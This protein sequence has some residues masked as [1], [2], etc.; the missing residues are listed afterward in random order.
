[1]T[2]T[3]DMPLLSGTDQANP[4]RDNEEI[5]PLTGAGFTAYLYLLSVANPREPWTET[6][7]TRVGRAIGANT[8]D[9]EAALQE[10]ADLGLIKAAHQP[11]KPSSYLVVGHAT[12]H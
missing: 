1:M 9:A 12:E 5:V 10:L 6:N 7:A 8:S 3:H 11:G 4:L 2:S